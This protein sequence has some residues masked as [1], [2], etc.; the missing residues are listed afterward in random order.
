MASSSRRNVIPTPSVRPTVGRRSDTSSFVDFARRMINTPPR[1]GGS[2]RARRAG[3]RDERMEDAAPINS[4]NVAVRG[5]NLLES[6]KFW[7][8]DAGGG[9]RLDASQ[10]APVQYE[11]IREGECPIRVAHLDEAKGRLYG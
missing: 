4:N 8:R 2:A 1:S 9:N 3:G 11:G 5:R 10:P 7:R 6:N